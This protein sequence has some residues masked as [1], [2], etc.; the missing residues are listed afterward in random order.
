MTTTAWMLALVGCCTL[1]TV[2][3]RV[4]PFILVRSITLPMIVLRWLSFIPICILTALIVQGLLIEPEDGGMT[5]VNW[6]YVGVAV[7]TLL[8][9]L[10]TK[11]L[12]ASVIVGVV[13]LALV[14]WVM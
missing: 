7:P 14:R 3:P 13:L 2:I 5:K 9:A 10:K 11:S 1:V 4:L 8:V 12:S 6:P